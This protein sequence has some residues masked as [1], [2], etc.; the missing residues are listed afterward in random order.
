M[1][2][3]CKYCLVYNFFFVTLQPIFTDNSIPEYL[4]ESLHIKKKDVTV[5]YNKSLSGLTL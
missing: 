5:R 4:V 2:H 1:S 3:F